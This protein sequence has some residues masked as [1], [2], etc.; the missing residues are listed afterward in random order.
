MFDLIKKDFVFNTAQVNSH[1]TDNAEDIWKFNPWK[2][3]GLN[4]V[5]FRTGEVENVNNNQFVIILEL[6][7]YVRFGEKVSEMSC[8]YSEIPMTMLA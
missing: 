5:L 8:G 2:E 1:W 6:V 4:P 3:N 7:I